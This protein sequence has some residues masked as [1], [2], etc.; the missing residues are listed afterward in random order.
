MAFKVNYA[1]QKAERDR[2]KQAKKEAKRREKEGQDQQE[3]SSAGGPAGG[4][5]HAADATLDPK[6]GGEEEGSPS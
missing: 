4:S 2:A 6:S 1:F 5:A 3:A